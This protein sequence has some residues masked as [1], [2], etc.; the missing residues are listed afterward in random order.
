VSAARQ[1]AAGA[2]GSPRAPSGRS[3]RHSLLRRRCA[4]ATLAA[5]QNVVAAIAG[6]GD[7][8]AA[9]DG[10]DA[11]AAATRNSE[12]TAAVE[13]ATAADATVDSRSVVDAAGGGG[14]WCRSGSGAAIPGRG[15]GNFRVGESFDAAVAHAVANRGC[16]DIFFEAK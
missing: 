11:G 6:T 8:A 1:A 16:Q 9:G 14:A 10:A 13:F 5:A 7:G 4:A 12:W 2:A 15:R 3:D